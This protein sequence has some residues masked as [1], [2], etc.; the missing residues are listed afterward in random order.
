MGDLFW[1]KATSTF[2]YDVSFSFAAV[3]QYM[4]IV[5]LNIRY[6]RMFDA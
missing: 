6:V 5:H 4:I 3:I 2:H 1:A